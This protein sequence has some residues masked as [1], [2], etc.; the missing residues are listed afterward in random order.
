MERVVTAMPLQPAPQ[1]RPAPELDELTLARA[2]R[3]DSRAWLT[4]VR[5][6]E[7]RVFAVASRMV[8]CGRPELVHD[9]AQETFLRVFRALPDFDPGGRARLSTWILTI[10]TRLAI[11]HMRRDTPAATVDPDSV[12]APERTDSRA[13]RQRLGV[14]LERALATLPPTQR[15]VVVLREW[16]DLDMEAIG[17]ALDLD[18]GAVRARL[19]R[20]RRAL[21]NT[22]RQG[23]WHV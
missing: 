13:E 19:F 6:Y 17:Q 1:V 12:V 10:A 5:C 21:R 7:A 4:L 8:G 14:A 3:G 20:A 18:A 2:Q 22:L 9:L 16:H 11:D 15:A 23:G